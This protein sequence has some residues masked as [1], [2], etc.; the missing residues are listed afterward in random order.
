MNEDDVRAAA[1]QVCAALVAGNVDGAIEYLSDEL[2]RNLGEVVAMLPLP[3]TEATISSMER[4]ASAIVVVL[5]VVGEAN[6]TELQTRW[7]DRDGDPRI[8][9]V[10]HLSQVEH[11]APA[12]ADE[13]VEAGEATT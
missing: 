10:S 7:K 5:R 3:A 4:G 1:E 2:K 11:E 13:D 12:A 8:V 6:E 9:E